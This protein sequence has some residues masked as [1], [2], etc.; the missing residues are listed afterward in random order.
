MVREE[1]MLQIWY[2]F[3]SGIGAPVDK[4]NEANCLGAS[5]TARMIP[6][7]LTWVGCSPPIAAGLLQSSISMSLSL[8][9]ASLSDNHCP[10]GIF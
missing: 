7:P 10:I 5:L 4:H 8:F 9:L 6:I 3:C 2:C 1:G